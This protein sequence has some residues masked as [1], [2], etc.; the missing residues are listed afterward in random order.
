MMRA[1]RTITAVSF[2]L[3]TS[4]LIAG[5]LSAGDGGLPACLGEGGG[6]LPGTWQIDDRQTQ[7]REAIQATAGDRRP[8]LEGDAAEARAQSDCALV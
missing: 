1:H 5:P 3:G 4:L 2:C 8:G 7:G 6:Q